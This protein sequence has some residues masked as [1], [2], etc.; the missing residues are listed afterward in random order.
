VILTRPR[1]R[2]ACAVF[3]QPT[4]LR[5]LVAIVS[6]LIGALTA[7]LTAW[8]LKHYGLKP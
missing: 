2:D 7:L 6:A 5:V 1:F 4:S 3:E 8:M